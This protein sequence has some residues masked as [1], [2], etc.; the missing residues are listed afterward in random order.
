MRAKAKKT[1]H[2]TNTHIMK[3]RSLRGIAIAAMTGIVL[4]ARA[5]DA[6]QSQFPIILQQPVDQCLPVGNPATFTVVA[7]N[8]D[9]YQWYKN[10]VALDDQTNSSL[11]IASVTT[12]DVAYYSATVLKGSEAIPTRMANLNVYVVSAPATQ[13]V[14]PKTKSFSTQS[15]SMSTMGG[16]ELGGGGVI[17]VYGMPV[18]SG[19]GSGSCPGRYSGYVNFIKT[20]ADW[21]WTPTAGVAHTA[22]DNNRADTKVVY[23]GQYGDSGCATN[24]VTIGYQMSPVYRFGIYFPT[25]VA[26]PTNA[27]PI[28]LSGF[29]P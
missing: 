10:N 11:A 18:T 7:T 20:N 24:S 26:V 13:T 21:G 9:S 14:T 23:V 5:Q 4:V 8:A 16:T 22:T 1:K 15:M 6:D 19:G 25:N 2:R 29:D 12:N 17:T 28:T 27:Y 3:I